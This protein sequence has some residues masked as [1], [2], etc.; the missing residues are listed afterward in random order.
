LANGELEYPSIYPIYDRNELRMKKL[1]RYRCFQLFIVV[2]AMVLI[3]AAPAAGEEPVTES[4]STPTTP[5]PEGAPPAS[6]GWTSPDAAPKDSGGGAAP[7]VHGTSLGSG[8]GHKQTSSTSEEPP[9]TSDSSHYYEPE[10]STPSTSREPT[11][12]PKKLESATPPTDPPA[13]KPPAREHLRAAVGAAIAVAHSEPPRAAG[14]SSALPAADAAPVAPRPDQG[15]SG[16][17][18]LGW[19]FVIV[20]G[21]FGVY[22]GLRVVF[23]PVEPEVFRA[24]IRRFR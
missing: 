16:L 19:L 3:I 4:P 15:V 21:L 8:G 20:C 22:A 14:T 2:S 18:T 23:G 1:R 11:S 6:T 5:T 12:T 10:P 7:T 24:G 13:P 9:S 17:G